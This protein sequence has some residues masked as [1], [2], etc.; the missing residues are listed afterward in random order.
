MVVN[1]RGM[2]ERFK[3]RDSEQYLPLGSRLRTSGLSAP[4]LAGS[5]L[6]TGGGGPVSGG[7]SV[8]GGGSGSSLGG[9]ST[10]RCARDFP[11]AGE[12]I[13]NG[14]GTDLVGTGDLGLLNASAVLVL[15][16]FGVAVEVQI[17]HDVP[18]GLAGSEGAAQAEDLTGKHP[19][20]ETDGVAS[21]VVGGDGNVDVLGGRVTV[22]KSLVTVSLTF[23]V[24]F[25]ALQHTMTGMLT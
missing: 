9:E 16:G 2:E 15:L 4:A 19:P 24:A 22:A 23:E 11:L 12:A 21:L 18:L 3:R 13:G 7:L 14:S 1:D 6:T 20:D 10:G 17:G 8:P 5:G 25:S